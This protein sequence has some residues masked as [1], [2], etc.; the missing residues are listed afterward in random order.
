MARFTQATYVGASSQTALQ[1]ISRWCT[2]RVP[3]TLQWASH[4]Y[5]LDQ[6]LCRGSRLPTDMSKYEMIMYYICVDVCIFFIH[7]HSGS[8][9]H[10]PHARVTR[11]IVQ[12][13]LRHAQCLR[14]VGSL[15]QL[16]GP[17]LTFCLPSELLHRPRRSNVLVD[18]DGIFVGALVPLSKRTNLSPKHTKLVS[19][20]SAEPRDPSGP[21]YPVFVFSELS[22]DTAQGSL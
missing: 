8:M 3:L 5:L 16:C 12:R 17:S 9:I 13:D 7:F 2:E 4:N 19:R 22:S 14:R 1:C 20:H 6:E 21:P 15:W 10:G 18:D 11:R